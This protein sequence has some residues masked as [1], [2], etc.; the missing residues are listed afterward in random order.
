MNKDTQQHSP[1]P[2]LK[3]AGLAVLTVFVVA[4]ALLAQQTL[5]VGQGAEQHAC[6]LQQGTC[7]AGDILVSI[8]PRPI[9][10]L[11]PFI[12]EV[13]TDDSSVDRITADLQGAEMYMGQNRFS[14][15][16][17]AGENRWQGSSELA[18]CTTGTMRW[19]LTLT[20]LRDDRAIQHQF[21]FDAK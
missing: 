18:V 13:R 7:E 10:S 6:D 19:R 16:P 9:Q 12:L 1:R 14:L 2:L 21:E 15:A 8:T 3:W 5:R 17:V 4:A 20:L 11:Q